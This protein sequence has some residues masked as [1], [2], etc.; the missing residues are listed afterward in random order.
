ML[1]LPGS[2]DGPQRALVVVVVV[3]AVALVCAGLV[4]VSRRPAPAPSGLLASVANATASL[5]GAFQPGVILAGGSNSSATLLGG[6]GVYDKATDFSLPVLTDVRDRAGVPSVEN[7]T[8]LINQ[9]FWE[10]GI[11]S[12]VWNGAEWLLTGQAGWGGGNTGT[13]I[14][15]D[16]SQVVNLTPMVAADFAGGGIWAAGWNGTSW[17]LGGNASAGPELVSLSGDR[18]TNLTGFVSAHA[19]PSWYQ[20]LEWNDNEWLLAGEGI[21]GLLRGT[22]YF[23]LFPASPFGGN[24]VYAAGW[25]GSAWLVGGG[26]G[27]LEVIRGSSL[28]PGP[29]LPADLDQS[30]LSVQPLSP[31]WLIAGKGTSA[32]GGIAPGLADWNGNAV[33]AGVTDLGPLLPKSFLGG[34]VW[35]AVP[36]S[37]PPGLSFYVVGQGAYNFTSGFGLGALAVLTFSDGSATAT[38]TTEPV[39]S[40][41]GP[42]AAGERER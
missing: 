35:G 41:G 7:T 12:I 3:V 9:Y 39:R 23:D 38:N 10:G 6:I 33:G 18:V 1:S 36:V 20:Y 21:L 5:G 13:A 11:Y 14:L 24:G 37:S 31:G 19:S 17:L 28:A 40:I 25:N 32:Q 27:H 4:T 16:G 42:G 8:A 29:P 34:E 15:V 30:I 22:D 2:S 26:S